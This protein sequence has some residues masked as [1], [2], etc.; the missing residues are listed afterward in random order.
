MEV[1][2]A[3][4]AGFCFGVRH[5]VEIVDKEIEKGENKRIYTYGSIINNTSVVK[6]YEQKGVFSIGGIDDVE[7]ISGCTLI[8]R[9]HGVAEEVYSKARECNVRVVDATC[10]FVK[11]IHHIVRVAS[12]GGRKIVVAGDSDHPEVLGITGWIHGEYRVINSKEEAEKLEFDEK[13]GIPGAT[14]VFQTTFNTNLY[15]IIVEILEKKSYDTDIINTICSATS[16]RQREA[17]EIARAVDAMLVIGDRL[18][19]NSNRLYSICKECCKNT[20]FIQSLK[21]LEPINLQ[22][23]ISVGI[24]AGASTPDNIIQEV[25]LTCQKKKVLTS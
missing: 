4:S 14:V 17:T 8:I 13:N 2:L 10:P 19:A 18:S 9:A 11:K 25:F 3:E 1:K 22:T 7:K 15:K 20:Y 12:D 5:A 23:G 6:S 16:N 24:T 21:D